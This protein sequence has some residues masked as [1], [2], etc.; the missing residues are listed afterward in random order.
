MMKRVERMTIKMGGVEG[1]H[2]SVG[3]VA[4]ALALGQCVPEE[5]VCAAFWVLAQRIAIGLP[6]TSVA[7][8]ER[9]GDYL[10]KIWLTP[11][12]PRN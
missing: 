3:L 12:S 11:V 8:A 4:I 2:D 6:R 1:V 9:Q 7:G 5:S 10:A